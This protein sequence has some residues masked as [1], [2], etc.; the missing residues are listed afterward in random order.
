MKDEIKV[1]IQCLVYNQDPYLKQCLDGFVMQKTNFKFEAIVHDDTSTDRSADIIR[2][3][4]EKYPDIIKPILET[5]NQY[6][7]H[8]G[9]LLRIMREHTCG[10]YV[11]FC[12]GDDYWIDPYKLQKQVDFL[13]THSNYSMIHTAFKCVDEHS[14]E[15][16]RDSQRNIDYLNFYESCMNQ[17]YSGLQFFHLLFKDNYILTCT[18]MMRK[19]II[20]SF[21][22]YYFDYG[23]FLVAARLGLIAYL[24]DITACYRRTPNSMMND[25]VKKTYFFQIS[26]LMVER[27]LFEAIDDKHTTIKDV[28]QYKYY[29]RS[30]AVILRGHIFHNSSISHKFKLLYQLLKHPIL[31]LPFVWVVVTKAKIDDYDC[32]NNKK[33]AIS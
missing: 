5:E 1:T 28:M 3:Y 12:E 2:Q 13:E 4:A 11:A 27:E 22:D 18:V 23:Y 14:T 7:K 16:Q 10:K 9:S 25:P 6:S 26:K 17:S 24:P 32:N 20:D 19:E 21:L 31:Y 30:L 33:V 29:L 15:I 8:D